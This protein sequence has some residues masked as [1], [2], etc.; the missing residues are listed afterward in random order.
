MNISSQIAKGAQILAFDIGATTSKALMTT[1]GGE[2]MATC[3]GWGFNLRKGTRA[4]FKDLISEVSYQLSKISHMPVTHPAMVVLGVA[5]GGNPDDREI[6]I[7]LLKDKWPRATILLNHDAYIAHY[8]A[9]GGDA[10]VMVTAGTG[11][12]AY[13]R[14]ADGKEARAGGWGWMLGDEGSGWWIG[15]Q[16]IKSVILENESGEITG[17]K[18]IVLESFDVDG[19]NRLISSVYK[20]DFDREIISNLAKQVI[21]AAA[22]G[23][24]IAKII[25][26]NAG[27]ELGKI[28][29]RVAQSLDINPEDLYVA[30][31]GSISVNGGPELESGFD[32]VLQNYGNE[33][34][35]SGEIDSGKPENE[36][37]NRLSPD[38]MT[39]DPDV[40]VK[41]HDLNTIPE[42][43]EYPP[44]DLTISMPKGPKR[45]QPQMD[46]LH[47]AALWGRNTLLQRSFA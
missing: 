21:E 41:N 20:E 5:G 22:E 8:G 23:N 47:G 7:E 1:V 46:A 34:T 29:V 3:E 42:M 10:G 37:K 18:D 6:L 24:D 45:V 19:V 31:L 36:M 17:L 11:S 35:G 28:A 9:F 43:P 27:C 4:N 30:L 44:R 15:K 2:D 32:E 38:E 33:D 40:Q 13:G 25:I 12:I 39:G 14:L 16:A 26:R